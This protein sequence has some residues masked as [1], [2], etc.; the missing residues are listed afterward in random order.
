MVDSVSRASSSSAMAS[1]RQSIAEDFDTF[2]SILT[3]QLKHQN[4]LDPMDTNQFTQQL[5]QFTGVE[6]QLKTNEYLEA[7]MLSSQNQIN[8]QAVGYI[9]QTVVASGA[10]TDLVDGQATWIYKIAEAS[11]DVTVTIKDQSGNV[12]YSQEMGMKAGTDQIVWD[13]TT[14]SGEVLTS[15]K[16]TITIDARDADGKAIDVTTK[17]K[18]VVESVDVSGT[19]P[20][21]IV[22]GLRLPLS[23][24]TEIGAADSPEE[25]DA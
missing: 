3:T 16:Y 13:G 19:E 1:S 23:S 8:S 20:Y 15:G 18:G 24:V 4:P 7:M 22:N 5:V 17:M 11:D 2:L 14:N 21:L 10:T 25:T 9:G 12:V 6:Q